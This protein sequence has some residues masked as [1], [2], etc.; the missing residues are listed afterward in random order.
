MWLLAICLESEIDEF[1]TKLEK[2]KET[3]KIV[4]QIP[5]NKAMETK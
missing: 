3:E 2:R 5:F 4:D 1:E